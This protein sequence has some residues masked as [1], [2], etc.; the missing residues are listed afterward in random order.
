[1]RTALWI[2]AP[3]PGSATPNY[4]ELHPWIA[5]TLASALAQNGASYTEQFEELLNDPD[6]LGDPTRKAYCQLALRRVSEVVDAFEASFDQGPHE[7]WIDRLELV[8]RAPDN[9][10]PNHSS[11]E[12]YRE[13]VDMNVGET[14]PGRHPVRQAITEL[15]TARWLATDPFVVPD[16]AQ[17]KIIED[18]Y[19]FLSRQSKRANVAALT[20]AARRALDLLL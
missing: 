14:P 10:S 3:K 11:G 5:Q 2:I 8:T 9:L 13:L 4:A 7:N 12:I 20:D 15:I 17:H 6:T 1:M 16:P 18:S 19:N